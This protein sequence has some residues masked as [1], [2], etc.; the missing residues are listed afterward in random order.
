[1]KKLKRKKNKDEH[2]VTSEAK[3]A[4]MGLPGLLQH[5][6]VCPQY[7]EPNDP[8]NLGGPEGLPGLYQVIFTLN[9]P[10]FSPLPDGRFSFQTGL[11]GDSHLAI[12]RPA[13]QPPNLPDA[14]QI[15]LRARNA[16]GDFIF[17]GLPNSKGFLGKI[18]LLQVRADNFNDAA[19]RAV[20]AISPALSHLALFHDIPLHIYQ[21]DIIELRTAAAQ[22]SMIAPFVSVPMFATPG[23]LPSAEFLKYAS[24]Y[25]EALNSNAVNYQFLCY[26][27][28]IE[29]VTKRRGRI[30]SEARERGQP[31]GTRP[32]QVLP[33]TRPEQ[34]EWMN[35]VFPVRREWDQMTLDSVFI[36]PA[37]GK[38]INDIIDRDLRDIRNKVAHAVLRSG[39][40]TISIDEAEDVKH[41][42]TWLPLVKCI[43]RFLLREEFPSMFG[44]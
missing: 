4:V 12:C 24:L 6:I 23:N 17:E 32:R 10:G 25:R 40:P 31:I 19:F 15:R 30:L 21:T 28:I 22:M 34:L 2:R 42:N 18:K 36:A 27:K 37:I 39:E 5:L 43:A 16:D 35:S 9:R 20:R 13:Y 11:E 44:R 8:R 33:C 26:Y 14:I 3:L 29:G 41:V 38:R 1:M 7:R